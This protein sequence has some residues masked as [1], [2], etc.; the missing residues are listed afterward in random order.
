[1]CRHINVGSNKDLTIKELAETIKNVVGFKRKINFDTSKPDGIPRKLL[2]SKLIKNFGL[3]Q[4]ISL[5]E[6]LLIIYKKYIQLK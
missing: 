3:N 1:M 6:R 4:E 5:K 2:D